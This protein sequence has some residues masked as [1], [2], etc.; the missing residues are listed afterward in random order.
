MSDHGAEI[1]TIGTE[2]L[3]GEI[4][5]SN[6][7][8]IALALRGIGL[9]MYRTTTVGDNARRIELAIREAAGRASVLLLAGGLGPTVDD[10]TREAV[11][12]AFNLP[13]Q[14]HQELWEEIKE[15]F[16][17]FGRKPGDNNRKQAS[18]PRGAVP[19]TNPIGTA[20]GFY[21]EISDTLLVALPGV[22]A[23]M[24]Y[25]L[26]K[27]VL[28]LLKVKF[29]L[30]HHI[31]TRL[32]RTAGAGESTIDDLIGDLELLNNPTVG[33]AAHPG[34][35]DIRITAKATTPQE[36]EELIWGV[37]ATLRQRLGDLVYGVDDD[38]LACV[39]V[40]ALT[41]TGSTLVAVESGTGGAL[42]AVLSPCGGAF[43]AGEMVPTL[44]DLAGLKG[45]IQ[46]FRQVHHADL[47]LGLIIEPGMEAHPIQFLLLEGEDG[48]EERRGYGGPPEHMAAWG[49]SAALNWL[50]RHS[51]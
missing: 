15:R 16:A 23:E 13:M 28:P 32:L 34:L 20:P 39:A 12:Q 10:V 41:R 17:R 49:V 5:D 14:F 37:E 7:R 27:T 11:A 46:R 3:L 40:K 18:L 8:D 48:M 38:S 45:E 51:A 35:V 36:C 1:I 22:P 42:S 50:R 6:T 19:I 43:L 29:K 4:L 2:L 33:L 30:H 44:V 25:L 24:R 26:D 47:G 31:Q 21:L 9:D